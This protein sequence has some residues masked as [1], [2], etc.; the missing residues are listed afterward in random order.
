MNSVIGN[1]TSSLYKAFFGF[2]YT[3]NEINTASNNPSPSLVSVDGLNLTTSD[4]NCSALISD[5]DGDD[6]DVSVRWFKNDVLNLSLDYNNSYENATLFSSILESGNT[7]KGENWSCGLRLFDGEDYSD[8]VNSSELEILNSLPTVTLDA[9]ADGSSTTNR[10]PEFSWTGSD[11]DGDSLT[12]DWNLTDYQFTGGSV[13]S[14][15]RLESAL[16]GDLFVPSFDLLCL[17]DNGYYYTWRVR[18]HDGTGYGEWSSDFIVNITAR[19]DIILTTDEL[20]FGSLGYLESNDSSDNSPPPFVIENNGTVFVNVSVNSSAIWS[21]AQ[22]NS[23]YYQFK[24]DN[25]SG[26][27]GAFSWLSSITSWFNSPINSYVVAI[28]SLNYSDDKDSA[29]IDVRLEVPPN[30]GPGAKSSTIIFKAELAE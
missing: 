12:Y 26:E 27:A 25:V 14:D 4:L 21:Q 16:E 9:P 28:D 2:W 22:S 18:A 1:V 13:C 10:T 6:L 24:V 29:E 23:S 30:E 19:V 5:A 3:I 17:H 8:W 20:N 15:S 11:A 7:S